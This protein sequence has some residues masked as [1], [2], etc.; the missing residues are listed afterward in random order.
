MKALAKRPEDRYPDA[1][2]FIHD[3]EAV[4]RVLAAHPVDAETTAKFTPPIRQSAGA[5]LST[6]TVE[7]PAATPAGFEPERTQETTAEP[8]EGGRRRPAVI[9]LVLLALAA[10]AVGGFLLLRPEQVEVPLVL[11]QNVDSA[12][13][14]LTAAGF[15]LDIDRRADQAPIDIVFRQVPSATEKADKGSVVTLFVSNG[16]STVKV[17][18]VLGLTED[19]ARSRIKRGGLKPVV[20]REASTK[21]LEGSVIRSDP[22][23]GTAIERESKVTLI[24]SK[25]P[26][27][28]TVPDV[29]GSDQEDA[30]SRLSKEG[31]TVVVRE[32]ASGEPVDTVVDQSPAAGQLVDEGSTVT[33]FV[34]NGKLDEVPDV[35]G[36][37]ES[38]AEADISDAGFTPSVKI[39]QVTEPDQDGNVLSQTPPSGK[40]HRRGGTVVITVGQLS[41][42]AAPETP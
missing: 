16:P 41:E 12:R 17:P 32:K 8:F 28:K 13:G 14:E 30:A 22:G 37:S 26:E 24:V 20:E 31:L 9:F 6:P 5:A 1:D 29:V 39:K 15:K 19:A 35:V 38:E 2:S 25:G 36:L 4:E 7:S 11:G 18:D 27:E 40:E 33:I 21:V 10:I 42:P 23:A 34:S 3:L